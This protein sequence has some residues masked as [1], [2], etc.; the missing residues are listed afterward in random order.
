[1]IP[2]VA[3]RVDLRRVEHA[4][5]RIG[6]ISLGREAARIRA[7]RSGVHLS[8]PS[9]S[10]LSTL[11]VSGPVRLRE[12]SHRTDLEA[13][14]ISREVRDLIAA[15]LVRRTSDPTD[16]RAG[17]VELTPKGRRASEAY[18]AAT[19]DIIA[20]TFSGW[21]AAELRVLAEQLERV[22]LDFARAPHEDPS[23]AAS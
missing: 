8:R 5:T 20:E 13:P 23:V 2:G 3:M 16:G 15:G 18:R 12:L 17:I 14:L 6:R 4:L 1:M 21:S 19:D 7:E 11:R 9:I 10:I 22:V